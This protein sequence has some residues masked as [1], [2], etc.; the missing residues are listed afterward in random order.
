MNAVPGD[1]LGVDADLDRGDVAHPVLVPQARR[2][3]LTDVLPLRVEVP[4]DEQHE[5]GL[6]IPI[7]GWTLDITN[8]R[9]SANNYFDH[10]V[11]GSSNIFF[12][13]ILARARIYGWETT[14]RSHKLFGVAQF[15]LAYSHQHAEAAGAAT[16]G[17]TDFTAPD[18]GFFFLFLTA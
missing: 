9:T 10:D 3:R 14:L 18:A 6:T 15:H 4:G 11:L 1:L 2:P 16:G 7:P 12:P 13:L 8:F 5:V 17:L